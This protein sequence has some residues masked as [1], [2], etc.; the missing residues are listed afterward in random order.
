MRINKRSL[1]S[2]KFITVLVLIAILGGVLRLTS[3]EDSPPSLNWDEISHGYNA[4]SILKTGRDE[5]GA[6]LP[7][8]NFRA[9]GDYPLPLNLYITIPF[10]WL[11]G[12]D[13]FSI[14]LPHAIL[15]TLTIIVT[16]FLV[17]GITKK[18][19]L[20]LF[21]ALLVAIEPWNVFPSR[22]VL[23]S[24]LSV[25]FL[26]AAAAAFFNREKNKYLLP[27][28]F[29]FFG[30]TLFSYHSTR[31]FTPLFLVPLLTIYR[32]ELA[33]VIKKEKKI[34]YL[35]LA[36]I[37]LFFAPL[38]FILAKPEAR[39]RSQAVFLIDEGAI[40]AIV[41]N[42]QTSNLPN[43]VKR[44]IYNKPVYFIEH[45]FQNYIE[46]FSP[47]F[48]FL[49]GGTQYQFSVPR[50]GLLLLIN[51][52]FF[53]IGVFILFKKAI[54][55][56]KKYQL[57]LAWLLISPIPASITTEHYAV[58]RA[59]TML[60]VPA[61][62][63]AMG[64]WVVYDWLPKFKPMI[65]AVYFLILFILLGRYLN[66]YFNDYKKN[67][68][69]AWQYGYKQAV[70]YAKENYEEYDKI[71]ITKK[72]GEPHEFF[73]FYWPWDPAKYQ[74]DPNLI[75]FFQSNWYWVDRF[76]KFYFVNDWE[77]PK[78]EGGRWRMENGGEIP[79]DGKMLLVTSPGNFPLGW[80][81]LKTVEFVD[82]KPAFDLLEKI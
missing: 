49:D 74:N 50:Q 56:D 79:V 46:Y 4:Y 37:I 16:Y 64:V 55:R 6:F 34:S 43:V 35:S 65:L 32:N 78:T 38:P 15:G 75:R 14:R 33:K 41:Q 28:S 80:T 63:S 44:I 19:T 23:Q 68:S 61:I 26:T 9:Y 17:Y 11:L 62:L 42:R 36:V 69:W 25:F 76:D 10:I 31:I 48:L 81:W 22:F 51:L 7:I 12:L 5:W 8:T 60:P 70:L 45:F 13:A 58:L 82:G 52:P 71:I 29:L 30:L 18:K 21:S 3:L 24:N 20:S 40:S 57:I 77:I 53:Y 72:Y 73:L 67:Y 1:S 39:A 2:N 66:N 27:L 54:A 59:S 47:K